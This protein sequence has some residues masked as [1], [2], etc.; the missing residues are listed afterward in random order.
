MNLTA[1]LL[2]AMLL[3]GGQIGAEADEPGRLGNFV[4]TPIYDVRV[5][6]REPGALIELQARKGQVVEQ[7]QVLGRVDDS[8]AQVRKLIAENE[9]NAA[10]TQAASEADVKAAEATVHVA[11]EEYKGSLAIQDIEEDAISEYQVRRDE[12]TWKRSQFQFEAAQVEYQIN[13]ITVGMKS[14]QLQAVENE[15]KRRV[16]EAPTTGVIADRYHN[17][18]EWAQAGEPIYRVVHMDRLR[19]EGMLNVADLTPEEIAQYP[20]ITIY[21]HYPKNPENPADT[22]VFR[23]EA[24]IDFT[25]LVVDHAGEFLISAEFDNPRR[26]VGDT[27]QWAVRPGLDAEAV[28]D[29]HLM[30]RLKQRRRDRG[31]IDW[32]ARD[33]R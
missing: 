3:T 8:D 13:Q 31:A 12:L 19:V 4:I 23:T 17:V 30:D 18:G 20:N 16:I 7:G 22:G 6:A 26:V 15:I 21:V 28:L 2:A 32:S 29:A 24:K 9:L 1:T 33:G 5:P 10:K 27:I 14:A 11:E 25:S